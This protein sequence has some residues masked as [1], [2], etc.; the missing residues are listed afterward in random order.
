MRFHNSRQATPGSL[1]PLLADFVPQHARSQKSDQAWESQIFRAVE[2]C[3]EEGDEGGADR[4]TKSGFEGNVAEATKK[5]QLKYL[6]VVEMMDWYGCTLFPCFQNHFTELPASVLVGIEMGGVSVWA[7][8]GGGQSSGRRNTFGLSSIYRWGYEPGSHF[9]IEVS[10]KLDNG[11]MVLF[12]L[13][14]APE[15]SCLLQDYAMA[16]LDEHHDEDVEG[17]EDEAALRRELERGGP[18]SAG[19]SKRDA[20]RDI[21]T[22]IFIQSHIRGFLHRNALHKENEE[23]SATLIQATFR[24]FIVRAEMESAHLDYAV[25]K[26]QAIHRGNKARKQPPF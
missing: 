26:I 3:I 15:V 23:W 6:C 10:E 25:S 18:A 21:A 2:A 20:T 22:A 19:I 4:M 5:L 11:P 16:L 24:G 8:E 7:A 9:Y 12:R 1:I 17:G 14:N 13:V